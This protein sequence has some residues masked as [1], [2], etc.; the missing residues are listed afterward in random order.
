MKSRFSFLSCLRES[1]LERKLCGGKEEE[2]HFQEMCIRCKMVFAVAVLDQLFNQLFNERGAF[3][4]G[5][6]SRF[7]AFIGHTNIVTV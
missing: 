3:I 6:M 2:M 7:K 1:G 5:Q 4:W